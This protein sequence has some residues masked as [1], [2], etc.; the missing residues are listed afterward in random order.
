MTNSRSSTTIEGME[1]LVTI[2]EAKQL[3]GPP[4]VEMDTFVKVFIVP[5]ESKV[6]Q[7][8]VIPLTSKNDQFWGST[9]REF[10]F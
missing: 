2:Q 10:L 3:L 7:T 8:K 6:L 1:L 5:D 9:N 4:D